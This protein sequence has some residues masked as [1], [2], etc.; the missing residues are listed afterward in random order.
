MRCSRI[1]K[2]SSSFVESV[3][4]P[5]KQ[6]AISKKP[7]PSDSATWSRI[8]S[9]AKETYYSED[10]ISRNRVKA[11]AVT[12][13]FTCSNSG[14]SGGRIIVRTPILTTINGLTLHLEICEKRSR[15]SRRGKSNSVLPTVA[16]CR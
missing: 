2:L 16:Q 4:S 8:P 3:G 7:V 13:G 9:V 5:S 11:M 15:R 10:P 12:V 1:S 14:A 6:L